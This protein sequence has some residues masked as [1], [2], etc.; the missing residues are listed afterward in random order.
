[1]LWYHE[2]STLNQFT[3]MI[4]ILSNHE[5]QW[6]QEQKI[7]RLDDEDERYKYDNYEDLDEPEKRV[8]APK[9]SKYSSG[10]DETIFWCADLE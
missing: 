4:T 7:A 9:K 2:Y 5:N 8:Y 6:K 3:N 10:G 1:M